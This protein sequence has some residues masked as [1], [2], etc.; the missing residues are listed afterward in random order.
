[1][2]DNGEATR[3]RWSVTRAVLDPAVGHEQAGVRPVLV[4]SNADFNELAG[5]ATIAPLTTAR[6]VP[7]PWEVFI[8]AESAGLEADSLLLVQHLRTISFRRFR[9]PTYGRIV[10]PDLRRAIAMRVLEHFDFDDL[11]ALSA[12]P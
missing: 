12:E 7:Q 11:D 3:F 2:A 1:M 6:R 8:P 9:P 5:L 10:D 4:L